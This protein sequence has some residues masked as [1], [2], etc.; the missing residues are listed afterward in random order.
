VEQEAHDLAAA[1]AEHSAGMEPARA[2]DEHL[3]R[4]LILANDHRPAAEVA[5]LVFQ[6]VERLLFGRR[7][8]NVM[9]ESLS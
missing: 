7:Q 6:A 2:D 3:A 9:A 4:A 8:P 1:I 5:G